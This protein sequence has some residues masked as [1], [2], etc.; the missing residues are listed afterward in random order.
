MIDFPRMYIKSITDYFTHLVFEYQRQLIDQQ[1]F[2]NIT[3]TEWFEAV[4]KMRKEFDG[5]YVGT[6][7]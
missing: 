3:A 4:D 2:Y 5:S 1:Y 6:I 7:R